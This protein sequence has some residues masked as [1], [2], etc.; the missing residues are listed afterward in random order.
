ML[1]DEAIAKLLDV[2]ESRHR[3]A[4]QALKEK[5]AYTL[6][7]K[8]FLDDQAAGIRRRAREQDAREARP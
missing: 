1:T 2:E 5:A 6:G 4:V 3:R 7:R 8:R